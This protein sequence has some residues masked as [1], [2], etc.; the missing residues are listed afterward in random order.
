MGRKGNQQ[1]AVK[2]TMS[3]PLR[4][5]VRYPFL[6]AVYML[7]LFLHVVIILLSLIR[8][9]CNAAVRKSNHH[10]SST[11]RIT[12]PEMFP[13]PLVTATA[14]LSDDLELQKRQR[15]PRSVCGYDSNNTIYCKGKNQ[16]CEGTILAT[17][18]IYQYCSGD[19]PTF[20]TTALPSWNGRSCP[21][22]ALCWYAFVLNLLFSRNR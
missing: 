20:W 8:S 22:Q 18:I 10:S 11:T 4:N 14:Q 15:Y 16:A 12:A 19:E 21:N 9:R 17:N 2:Y 5:F 3:A 1:R 7:M 6:I 13:L